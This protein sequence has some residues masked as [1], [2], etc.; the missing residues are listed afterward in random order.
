MPELFTRFEKAS[1][2]LDKQAFQANQHGEITLSQRQNLKIDDLW[3]RLALL[4][5]ATPVI[6]S[7]FGVIIFNAISDDTWYT[8]LPFILILG[9]ISLLT[10]CYGSYQ[11]SLEWRKNN[12]RKR[13]IANNAISLGQGQLSHDKKGY[14][15]ELNTGLQ[16]H[17]PTGVSNGLIPGV[18]YQL[19]Y[20]EESGFCLSA[21]EIR[22]T[23]QLQVQNA[24]N[25]IL[26]RA[27]GFSSEDLLANQN[28]EVTFAQRKKPFASVLTGAMI[29]LLFIIFLIPFILQPFS[30][31]FVLSVFAVVLIVIV[32]GILP[33]IGTM[34]LLNGLID[35]AFPKLQQMQGKVRKEIRVSKTK[36]Q[37][38]HYY[39]VM[40]EQRFEV[41]K[42]AYTALIDGLEYRIYYLPRTKKLISIEHIPFRATTS[43]L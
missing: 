26:G 35:F 14:S 9:G 25:E 29:V 32:V 20:L 6:T 39:Y 15:F 3:K 16:L 18:I 42:T 7:I 34:M 10:L 12:R 21:A 43:I 8:N 31:D 37:S 1:N 28:N 38:V 5:I 4:F 23:S 24:L 13:D 30:Q 33:F 19:F 36:N 17:L 11:L 22:Q 40:G 41:N 2:L 27:N